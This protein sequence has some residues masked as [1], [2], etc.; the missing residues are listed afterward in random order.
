MFLNLFSQLLCNTPFL[1]EFMN[2]Y[3]AKFL[4]FKHQL[5]L[6]TNV[7]PK[8]VILIFKSLLTGGFHEKT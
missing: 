7:S 6:N 3:G 1:Q 4:S 8:I 2:Y 5:P